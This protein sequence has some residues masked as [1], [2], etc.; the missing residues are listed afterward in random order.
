[1]KP[2]ILIVEDEAITALEIKHNLHNWGYEVVG[3]AS[4]AEV[5]IEMAQKL[6]PDLILM[7][8][9]LQGD[10][11][12]LE[13]SR[14]I[15][16]FL[17][18]PIIFITAHGNQDYMEQARDTGALYYIIKPFQ[19]HELKYA[20]ENS[21]IHHQLNQKLKQSEKSYR[22]LS[23][24][25]PGIVYRFHREEGRTEFFNDMLEEITGFS[26]EELDNKYSFP[27][28]SLVIDSDL[29]EIK[30]IIDNALAQGE[31]FSIEY[32]LKDK[33][34]RIKRV[35]DKGRPTFDDHGNLKTIEGVIFE[36]DRP[37]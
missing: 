9:N 30:T 5:A 17:D 13:A 3:Q 18:I 10:I 36:L 35:L 2:R 4:K 27:I 22:S 31:S 16:K 12:G 29:D 15:L 33:K 1:M 20:V 6:R 23:K 19:N 11:N 24:N 28:N 7:D 8:I 37:I 21:L 32:Q 26:P 34:G 14:R 25:I